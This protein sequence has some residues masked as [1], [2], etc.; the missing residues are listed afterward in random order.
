MQALLTDARQP[1][2][3]LSKAPLWALSVAGTLALGIGAVTAMFTVGN[4]V[5]LRPLPYPEPDR[6][7]VLWPRNPQKGLEQDR[8]TL[9]DFADWRARAHI[10]DQ[11]G[12][13]FLWSETRLRIVRTSPSVGVYRAVVPSAWMRALG[14]QPL[15][16]RIF[17]PDEDRRGAP[18]A[19]VISDGFWDQQFGRDPAVIGRTLVVDSYALKNYQI[20]GVMPPGLQFPPETD[21]WLS[22]GASQFEPPDPGAGQRCC[23]WLEVLARLR[24]GVSIQQ[25][26]TELN[27]IQSSLLTG[28][29]PADVNPAVTVT[30]L[31]RYLT[32]D[33]RPAHLIPMP[34]VGCVLLVACFNA[35]KLLLARS[36][37]RRHAMAI[38]SALGAPR[39]RI[40][41]QLLTESVMLSAAGRLGRLAPAVGA[42]KI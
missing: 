18:L 30:P 23:A 1:L 6:L 5:L 22:L 16:G 24:R 12:Y 11:I 34:A 2:R 26:Q 36:D 32:P 8:V 10:F 4:A 40:I 14:V 28:H 39:L 13:S 20:A 31:A 33:V 38:R 3:R 29:G 9:A 25:A 27:G 21:V 19:A 37:L 35:A 17:T 7:A 41:P 42:L 15:R